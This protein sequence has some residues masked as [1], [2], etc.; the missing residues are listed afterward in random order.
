[1]KREKL[2]EHSTILLS[3]CISSL[4]ILFV[5]GCSNSGTP[6]YPPSTVIFD[7]LFDWTTHDRRALGSDNWPITWA[8]DDHQYTAWGDGVG[9]G[10][11][12][13]DEQWGP[14]RAS[15]GVSRIEGSSTSYQS[16]NVWGGKNPDHPATFGGKSYG[17]ISID[18]T[19]Y[20]WVSPGSD[21]QNY[22][23]A[24]LYQSTNHGASWTA[25]T[26][27]FNKS[28]GLILPTFLQFGKDYQGAR[29]DFVYIYTNHFKPKLLS[30]KER[31]RVHIPG[32]IALIR[33]PK[34]RMMEYA[35]YE[36]FAG[37]NA[38]G[39]PIWTT[40]LAAHRPVFTDAN[41][42][43]W[44]SSVS[45]NPGLRRYMLM[46][47][48]TQTF[49]GNLGIFDAPEPWGPWTTIKYVNDFGVPVI[50]A[51]TFFWNFSPKWPSADGKHFTLVFTGVGSN[52]SW[53]TVRGSFAMSA[54]Y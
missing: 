7:V 53:N 12:N 6:P 47:E 34:A 52:D 29:D 10:A 14:A 3:V 9:F 24:Q 30:L 31:L 51:S 38:H 5:V 19:L 49:R 18:G 35:A 32:E 50:E 41:G 36:F 28:E 27:A 4:L 54:P 44:N 17:I 45:Y 25:A 40:N 39:N 2:R 21:A 1:M 20:M 42:V 48:H 11:A 16:D 43:G 46:T 13:F 23:K 26:W 37:V 8:D 15:L 22:T 33:V